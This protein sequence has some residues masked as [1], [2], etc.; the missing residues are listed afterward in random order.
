MHIFLKVRKLGWAIAKMKILIFSFQHISLTYTTDISA[1]QSARL[2]KSSLIRR[3]SG[4]CK[5]V[6]RLE[7]PLDTFLFTFY[8]LRP[9]NSRHHRQRRYRWVVPSRRKL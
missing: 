5:L 3:H 1:S 2:E 7:R 8:H 9:L 4:F 6:T